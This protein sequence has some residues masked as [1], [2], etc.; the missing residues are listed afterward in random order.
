MSDLH[1]SFDRLVIASANAGK[2]REVQQ[3]LADLDIELLPRSQWNI[4]SPC[5]TGLTFVENAILKARH[6]AAC[7][8]LPALADDSGLIVEALNGAPGVHSARFAGSHATCGDNICKLLQQLKGVCASKRRAQL[9]CTLALCRYPADPNPL[10]AHGS[11]EGSILASPQGNGGFG[12]DQVFYVKTHDCSA[13]QLDPAEKNRLSHRG[14]A[15]Q[16]LR[17]SLAQLVRLPHKVATP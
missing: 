14:M 4:P 2:C 8:G 6:A 7:T 1:P 16:K 12:Y 3:L 13:A 9:H 5:E 17:K 10:L 11:W 15:F